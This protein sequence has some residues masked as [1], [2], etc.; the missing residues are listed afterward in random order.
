MKKYAIII[1]VID[2]KYQE[3]NSLTVHE[4]TFDSITEAYEA[5]INLVLKDARPG[6]ELTREKIIENTY[7]NGTKFTF[8]MEEEIPITYQI[9]GINID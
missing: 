2:F 8:E 6:D 5:M 1:T 4:K 3:L 9:V 7:D